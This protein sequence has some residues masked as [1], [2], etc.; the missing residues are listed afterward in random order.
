MPCGFVV[1]TKKKILFGGMLAH[2]AYD[3]G[4]PMIE[5][6]PAN[7]ELWALL[8][9]DWKERWA[10]AEAE[11]NERARLAASTASQKNQS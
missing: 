1:M 2:L 3:E 9:D 7:T 6:R 8:N 11:A 4:G 5:V 10:S